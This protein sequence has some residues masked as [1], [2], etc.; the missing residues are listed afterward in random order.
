M[1]SSTDH[2]HFMRIAL[3]EAEKAGQE[4][5]SAVGSVIVRD[6]E[7]IA[8]GRNLVYTTHDL[9]A[10]AE[11]VALREGGKSL[12]SVDFTGCTLYTTF[13]PCPMCCGAILLSGV[14]TLVMGGRND[15]GLSNWGDYRVEKLIE[16]LRPELTVNVVTGVLE[17]EG[18]AILH[19]YR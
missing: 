13:E 15:P 18:F 19:R 9:T 3:K 14:D 8:K 16:Q 1:T 2:E 12:G 11:T 7:V 10:H 4:G 17:D 6:G 5:N